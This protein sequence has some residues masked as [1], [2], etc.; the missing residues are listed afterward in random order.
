M[1][2]RRRALHVALALATRP[3]SASADPTSAPSPSPTPAADCNA[4]IPC[5]SGEYCEF[6]Y[7]SSGQEGYCRPCVPAS[8]GK[9][10][11]S[12]SCI[13]NSTKECIHTCF[14]DFVCSKEN[15]CAVEGQWCAFQLGDTGLCTFCQFIDY[16]G[17]CNELDSL[18][19]QDACKSSCL[20]ACSSDNDCEDGAFCALEPNNNEGYCTECH[21]LNYTGNP[22]NCQQSTPY[23]NWTPANEDS[24]LRKCFETCIPGSDSC[25][26]PESEFCNPINNN[27]GYCE[28]CDRLPLETPWDCFLLV[29]DTLAAEQCASTCFGGCTLEDDF[30]SNSSC[31]NGTFCSPLYISGR[32]GYCTDCAAIIDVESCFQHHTAAADAMEHCASTCFGDCSMN[33]SCPE[34]SFCNF[35]NG[36]EGYCSPCSNLVESTDCM[37]FSQEGQESCVASCYETCSFEVACPSFVGFDHVFCDFQLNNGSMGACAACPYP[38]PS[39]CQTWNNATSSL[40]QAGQDACTTTCF[41]PCKANSVIVDCGPGHTCTLNGYCLP[42]YPLPSREEKTPSPVPYTIAPLT[43]RGARVGVLVGIVATI[44]IMSQLL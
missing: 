30:G 3:G 14:P 21:F 26:N 27:M 23:F 20:D 15:P 25:G 40:T 18:A 4:S 34:G 19:G 10:P 44:L 36:L 38:D 1:P 42:L 35:Q 13:E 41:R 12:S 37:A 9:S 5:D 24:C 33:T 8:A 28:T 17:K 22:S 2:T 16:P 11:Y 39:T 31:T 32:S 29:N 6:G 7:F 43:S